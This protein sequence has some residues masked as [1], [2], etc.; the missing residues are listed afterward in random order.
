MKTAASGVCG[1]MAFPSGGFGAFLWLPLAG[2]MLE[3]YC[4][5]LTD[6]LDWSAELLAGLC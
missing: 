3:A 5:F 1:G 6:A 2:G 4:E